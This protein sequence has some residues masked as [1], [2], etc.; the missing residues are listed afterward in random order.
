VS[1]GSSWPRGRS[2]TS[3]GYGDAIDFRFA[4]TSH[5]VSPA[6]PAGTYRVRGDVRLSGASA[7]D[8]TV[9]IDRIVEVDGV[10]AGRIDAVPRR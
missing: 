3:Y 9:T 4:Q 2:V 10:H 6:L 8:A 5:P 1:I 7:P